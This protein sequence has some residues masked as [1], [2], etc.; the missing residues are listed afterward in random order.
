MFF[1]KYFGMTLCILYVALAS[2]W[3]SP[4]RHHD[5]ALLGTHYVC[6]TFGICTTPQ[7]DIFLQNDKVI[8]KVWRLMDVRLSHAVLV[9][10]RRFLGGADDDSARE[11]GGGAGTAHNVMDQ[12]GICCSVAQRPASLVLG[13]YFWWAAGTGTMILC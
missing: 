10:P 1:I 6:F 7:T 3:Q 4:A 8:S 5:H 13:N 12:Q 2:L 11:G 9:F